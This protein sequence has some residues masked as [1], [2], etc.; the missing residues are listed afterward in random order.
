MKAIEC[1]W[2]SCRW[3][4]NIVKIWVMHYNDVFVLY[5]Y[6]ARKEKKK[7]Y[8]SDKHISLPYTRFFCLKKSYCL[9][10]SSY[11]SAF[12]SISFIWANISASCSFNFFILGTLLAWRMLHKWLHIHELYRHNKWR[13]IHK[14]LWHNKWLHIYK[15]LLKKYRHKDCI[16]INIPWE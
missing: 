6:F 2:L 13:H 3:S 8:D 5:Y 12:F 10:I 15:F 7:S 1:R 11:F 14:F 16:T 4:V 9:R